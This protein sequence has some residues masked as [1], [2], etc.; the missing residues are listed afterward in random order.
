MEIR[1]TTMADYECYIVCSKSRSING[2]HKAN[3]IQVVYAPS[4]QMA[5]KVL[6]AKVAMLVEMGVV[7]HL[8]GDVKAG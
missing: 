3:H 5:D 2:C 4:T 8:Y 6:A 1:H 7:V